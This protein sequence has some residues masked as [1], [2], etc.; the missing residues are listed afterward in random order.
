MFS[1]SADPFSFLTDSS[2]DNSLDFS[3]GGLKAKKVWVLGLCFF[4]IILSPACCIRMYNYNG[5]TLKHT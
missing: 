3:G 4:L 5:L 1:D 2:F